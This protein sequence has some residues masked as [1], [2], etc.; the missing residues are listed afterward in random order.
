MNGGV[1]LRLTPGEKGHAR[2]GHREGALEHGDGRHGN[3]LRGVL[4]GAAVSREDHVGL[5]EGALQVHVVVAQRLVHGC[6]DLL[7]SD[8][9]GLEVVVPVRQDL[10]LHDGSEP[11]QLTDAGVARQNVGVLQDGEGRRPPVA[12]LQD[13]PPLGEAGAGLVVLLAAVGHSVQALGGGLFVRAEELDDSLVHL[14]AGDDAPVLDQLHKWRPVVGFLVQRLLEENHAAQVV[15]HG[16]VSREQQL[17]VEPAVLFRVLHVDGFQ[18]L[19]DRASAFIRGKDP[20]SRSCYGP[21]G[22]C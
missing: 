21:S 16:L 5:E 13:A 6:E 9:A 18:P 7:A 19:A 10:R 14:D 4:L 2:H 12:D 1:D 20:L 8:H 22:G 3:L 15:P 11:V 17:T